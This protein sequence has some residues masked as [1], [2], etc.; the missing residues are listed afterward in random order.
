MFPQGATESA[1]QAPW[2]WVWVTAAR[3]RSCL[4]WSALGDESA[5]LITLRLQ[6]HG[7]ALGVGSSPPDL[8]SDEGTRA[9]L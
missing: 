5:V 1:W 9:L 6:E 3:L 2:L 8:R 7:V 4:E